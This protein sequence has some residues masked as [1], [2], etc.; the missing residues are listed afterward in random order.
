MKTIF[1]L[2]LSLGL[3]CCQT[4]RAATIAWDGEIR[5]FDVPGPDETTFPFTTMDALTFHVDA[6]S[7]LTLTGNPRFN[8]GIVK[9]DRAY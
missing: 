4:T 7:V 2:L 6:P 9:I 8:H 3:G 5:R 1:A